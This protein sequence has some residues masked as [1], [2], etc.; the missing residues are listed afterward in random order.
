MRAIIEETSSTKIEVRDKLTDSP[1]VEIANLR[2]SFENNHVLKDIN[3]RIKKGE[4]VVVL[5][6]SGSGKWVR[7]KCIIRL[8]APG[9]GG[10]D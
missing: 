10:L 6:K 2:K 1:V 9:A 8:I 5:G 3:L 4:N 7:I